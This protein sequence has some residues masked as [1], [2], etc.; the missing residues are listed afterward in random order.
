MKRGIIALLTAVFLAGIG[1]AQAV[2]MIADGSFETHS[3]NEPEITSSP[4]FADLNSGG[5]RINGTARTGSN[6]VQWQWYGH[7]SEIGQTLAPTATVKAGEDYELDFWYR[8]GA[9]NAGKANTNTLAVS[10][11]TSATHGGPYTLAATKTGIVLSGPDLVYHNYTHTF[12][13]VDLAAVVGE[14]MQVRI[15]QTS[16]NNFFKLWIDDVSLDGPL[17]DEGSL[18]VSPAEG[19]ALFLSD[20]SGVESNAL[21]LSYSAGGLGSNMVVSSVSIVDAT[22][23]GFSV[24]PPSLT[25]TTPEPASEQVWVEFDNGVGGLAPNGTASANVEII[26]NDA[27]T[28]SSTTSTVPV[29]ATLKPFTDD[30]IIALYEHDGIGEGG[31]G[32]VVFPLV[33]AVMAGLGWVNTSGGSSDGTYGTLKGN[34]NT[35]PS[36]AAVGPDVDCTVSITN[37]TGYDLTL[38]S[39][40]F[41]AAKSWATSSSNLTV[42]LSGDLGSATLTNIVGLTQILYGDLDDFDVDLTTLGDNVLA[43]G[44]SATFTFDFFGHTGG[45]GSALDNILILGSGVVQAEL[46]M[47]PSA[48]GLEI[49]ADNQNDSSNVEISYLE[50]SQETNINVSSIS[51][52]EDSSSGGFTVSP[53]SL[54][55]NSPAPSNQLVN[56]AYDNGSASSPIAENEEATANVQIIWNE[57][58]SALVSTST[59]PV[60]VTYYGITEDNLLAVWHDNF[61]AGGTSPEISF[62]GVDAFMHEYTGWRAGNA[63]ST[64]GTYGT[65][66][67]TN[68]VLSAGS[69]ALN[70]NG[71]VLVALTN[72]T[73]NILDLDSINFDVSALW[74]GPEE[75]SLSMAGSLGSSNL[76][77]NAAAPILDQ[78]GNWAD[79]DIELNGSLLDGEYVQFTFSWAGTGGSLGL[80]NLAIIGEGFAP[81]VLSRVS[82]YPWVSIGVSGLDTGTSEFV[83]LM[84]AAGDLNTNVVITG[85]SVSNTTHPGALSASGSFPV[86]LLVPDVTNSAIFEVEFDNTVAN[87]PAGNYAEAV[88]SVEWTEA[89]GTTRFFEF[90]AYGT[91]PTDIPTNGVV[92]LFDTEFMTPDA[93]VNGVLGRFTEG[94][95]IQLHGSGKGQQFGSLDGT[96]GSLASPPASTNDTTA[97]RFQG[98]DPVTVLTITNGTTAAIEL[99]TFNFDI[100]RWYGEDNITGFTLGV[101]G[102]V[103]ANPA[104]YYS[105]TIPELGWGVNVGYGEHAVDLAAALGDHT[106]GA[107]EVIIFTFTLDAIPESS[108]SIGVWID[109]VALLGS[110]DYYGGWAAVH[111]VGGMGENPDGDAMDNLMEYATGGDPLNPDSAATIWAD[112]E[113]DWLYHVHAER[114]DDDSLTYDVGASSNLVW[115][116][117]HPDLVEEVGATTGPGTFR[118]V[119]NRTEMDLS[120]KF[121]ALEVE[122]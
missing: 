57:V 38:D 100:G 43:N 63:G 21:D 26:W 108:E 39:L 37:T 88:V 51:I 85:V 65:V 55:L 42:S 98:A 64:D 40:N 13:A 105:A 84:F 93:S 74:E 25:L 91:R 77:V 89:G 20:A 92:A 104:L 8:L 79:Y 2:D 3:G 97:W 106:L 52:I 35:A 28:T 99:S 69:A 30:Q 114:Q 9:Y 54:I 94:W 121:I 23:P 86:E 81:A 68:V 78:I 109:N 18:V 56:V 87:L 45:G 19:V 4:W 5:T 24:S 118:T 6:A 119:T 1:T 103:T 111:S 10:I 36:C 44:E 76:L 29:S 112:E 46:Q 31:T 47:N 34:A 14:Y 22:G 72:N 120:S 66:A 82:Q 70:A 107:G 67:S 58:G 80:D 62:T 48:V 95:G 96:Y 113:G 50:G 7:I 12:T 17:P 101:S 83:D 122:Q 33:D 41:D 11:Y 27:S 115:D 73:G 49:D 32:D 110:T 61:S 59:V 116:T 15:G 75:F 60:S 16:N 71:S 90:Y 102:D 53:G 117:I